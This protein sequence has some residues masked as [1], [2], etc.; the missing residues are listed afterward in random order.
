MGDCD[1]PC[2]TLILLQV[3]HATFLRDPLRSLQR[4]MRSGFTQS[5]CPELTLHPYLHL[6]DGTG[7]SDAPAEHSRP[8]GLPSYCGSSWC[9]VPNP[10]LH[11][12]EART[13]G[14]RKPS[15]RSLAR[16][17]N[18]SRASP[19]SGGLRVH[20]RP[21]LSLPRSRLRPAKTPSPLSL[22]WSPGG[23]PASSA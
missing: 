13:P 12:R 18:G 11:T 7:W 9:H 3:Q 19:G 16:V 2:H 14:L 22:P 1:S 6:P 23:A 10:P 15:K 5:Q 4:Q 17:A 20:F 21:R 8:G